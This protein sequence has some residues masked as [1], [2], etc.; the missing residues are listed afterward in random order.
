VFAHYCDGSSF[1]SYRPDPIS[2]AK[3][4]M[5]FRGRANLAATLEQLNAAHGLGTASELILSGGSAGGLAVYYHL[6]YVAGDTDAKI[7]GPEVGPT[8][9]VSSCIP[10]FP[11]GLHGPTRI[12][13]ANLTRFSLQLSCGRRPPLAG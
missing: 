11:T 4:P 2:T 10:R 6:D 1:S 12:F 8:A 5:W 9:V 13:W 3:G 7:V